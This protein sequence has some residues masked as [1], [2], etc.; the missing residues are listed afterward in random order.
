M[1]TPHGRAAARTG[2]AA[3]W[4]MIAALAIGNAGL[5]AAFF[6]PIELLLAQQ[7]A[8]IA[9]PWARP[10][11]PMCRSPKVTSANTSGPSL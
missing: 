11:A 2:T 9:P 10:G 3:G 6:G 4:A 7:A 5:W 1:A 8:A